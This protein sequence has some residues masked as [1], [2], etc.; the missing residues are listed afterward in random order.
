L[1][2]AVGSPADALA[3]P[4]EYEIHI[5]LPESQRTGRDAKEILAAAWAQFWEKFVDSICSPLGH[6]RADPDRFLRY[7]YP[8]K[9]D[10]GYANYLSM[11]EKPL[12]YALPV[13]P[14]YLHVKDFEH[15]AALHSYSRYNWQ[16]R[17][18]ARPSTA[19]GR[20][21]TAEPKIFRGE[22]F[23]A[24][25]GYAWNGEGE[26]E[27]GIVLT[28][29]LANFIAAEGSLSARGV[30]I[31]TFLGTSLLAPMFATALGTSLVNDLDKLRGKF[32]ISKRLSDQTVKCDI[33]AGF[34]FSRAELIKKFEHR[35]K[36]QG[37]AGICETQS[38]LAALGYS[39]GELDGKAGPH[40]RAAA[41]AFVAAW[42]I[43]EK[44]IHTPVF[45][46]MIARALAGE[47]PP[48]K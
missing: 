12:A 19:F 20:R 14:A 35:L 47:R 41:R 18:G 44:D 1:I 21:V 36:L 38:A 43:S 39:P 27:R 9:E 40:Y 15:D 16:Y 5:D 42:G 34:T 4:L 23:A 17:E 25:V 13:H 31:A 11:L 29:E 28:V 8:T 32:V 22:W 7:E 48:G 2:S 6:E 30:V 46:N 10:D 45:F 24:G 37:A 3:I 26:L 33:T